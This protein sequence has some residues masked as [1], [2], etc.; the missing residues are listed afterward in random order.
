MSA[1]P[2]EPC[3]DSAWY[4]VKEVVFAKQSLYSNADFCAA[5]VYHNL[6]ILTGPCTP[7]FS[8]SRLAG[9]AADVLEQH[10]DDW[11]GRPGGECVGKRCLSWTP[12]AAR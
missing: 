7:I 5:S 9:W 6:G 10:A 3:R 4:R 1:E 12:L 11:L 8:V 2:A